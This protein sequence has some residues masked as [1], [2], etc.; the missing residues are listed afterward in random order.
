VSIHD[1]LVKS[2]VWP[3]S[4]RNRAWLSFFSWYSRWTEISQMAGHSGGSPC[5]LRTRVEKV[6]WV[7]PTSKLT[8]RT[9]MTTPRYSRRV[10]TS[11][12]SPRTAPQVCG[13]IADGPIQRRGYIPV[14]LELR[15]LDSVVESYAVVTLQ[16]T[17]FR[18]SYRDTWMSM[19]CILKL[20]FKDK[21]KFIDLLRGI[22]YSHQ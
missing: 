6:S 1:V 9:S 3:A 21:E 20:A 13:K 16:Y 4:Q 14:P 7:T 2:Y 10:S 17:E 19:I 12:T 5:L 22:I 8:S 15:W 11:A 18:C